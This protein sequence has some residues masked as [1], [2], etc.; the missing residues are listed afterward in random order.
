[1]CRWGEVSETKTFNFEKLSGAELLGRRFSAGITSLR[2]L[3]RGPEIIPL[4]FLVYPTQSLHN[5]F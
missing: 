4:L 2:S 3:V 1:M 5:C